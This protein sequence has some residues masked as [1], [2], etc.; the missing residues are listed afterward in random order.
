[1]LA[2]GAG[3]GVSTGR[4]GELGTDRGVLMLGCPDPDL[5]SG[6]R[7]QISAAVT[8]MTPTTAAT[9]VKTSLRLR[10]GR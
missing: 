8:T 4:L 6:C 9:A 10:G 2:D 7:N 5:S 1:V 3:G